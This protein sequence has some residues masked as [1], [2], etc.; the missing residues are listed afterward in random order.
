MSERAL[1]AG[2]VGSVLGARLHVALVF[3]AA[4]RDVDGAALQPPL[5]RGHELQA[6]ELGAV[7]EE[8]E[9]QGFFRREPRHGGLSS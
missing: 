6:I 8:I 9:N 4:E 5:R 3:H 1:A 2:A 7:R